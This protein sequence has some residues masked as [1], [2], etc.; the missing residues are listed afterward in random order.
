VILLLILLA[1]SISLVVAMAYSTMQITGT[2]TITADLQ[3][4]YYVNQLSNVDSS[5]DKGTHS[6]FTAQKYGPDSISDTLT[7]QNTGNVNTTLLLYVNSNDTTHM[8]WNE[9]GN[10]PYLDAKTDDNLIATNVLEAIAGDFGFTDSNIS[11][12]TIFSVSLQIYGAVVKSSYPVEVFLWDGSWTSLGTQIL[13]TSWQWVNYSVTAKLNT[14][15]K[16]DAAKI[17]FVAKD[18][19]GDYNV[20]CARLE[21]NYTA[22]NY[23]LDLEEQWTS[24]DYSQSNEE[25]CINA[26]NAS[27]SL[28]VDVWN[29]SAWQNVI[30]SLNN[31]WNNVSISAYLTSSNFTM[32]FKGSIETADSVM[33]MWFVDATLIH[34]WT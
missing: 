31:G 6:N 25:L 2:I 21:V 32:R 27:E 33:N 4:D 16:I 24:V 10:Q 12:A 22:P 18:S 3:T 1:T 17:Y 20:D 13:T 23:E 5:P 8:N 29:G 15:S 14:W 34:V 7:E 28:R 30:A 9:I 11:S 19:K 26:V